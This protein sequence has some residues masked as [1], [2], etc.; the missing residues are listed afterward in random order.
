MP[1]ATFARTL[2]LACLLAVVGCDSGFGVDCVD[3]E[4]DIEDVPVPV[5]VDLHALSRDLAVG[6]GGTMLRYD[7][8]GDDPSWVAVES[9][10]TADLFGVT[11][12]HDIGEFVV[13]AA[14]TLVRNGALV[15]LGTS[16]DLRAVVVGGERGAIVGD[17]VIFWTS[18]GGHTWQPASVPEG[19]G[20]LRGVYDDEQ[21]MVAVGR[22]GTILISDDGGA[23][24]STIASPTSADLWAVAR[25][26]DIVIVGDAGTILRIIDDVVEVV[27][28][29]LGGVGD[30][31]GVAGDW[32]FGYAVGR[33]GLIVDL[34]PTEGGPTVVDADVEPGDLAAVALEWQ[35]GETVMMA[36]GA[37]GH[38]T[39]LLSVTH[40]SDHPSCGIPG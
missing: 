7:V 19:T 21:R 38:A 32:E 26:R 39:R 18:D 25:A 13:G 37:M 6:S 36:V 24:W 15:D 1:T 9:P 33:D 40:V 28:N 22:S 27:P 34:A 12:D 29:P 17:G 20:E 31:R 5:P 14:G 4:I 30:L 11:A 3:I 10:T 35:E 2:T 16:A 23:N 8:W